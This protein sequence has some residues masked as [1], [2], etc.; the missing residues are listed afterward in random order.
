MTN[1][2]SKTATYPIAAGDTLEFLAEE[3]DETDPT[4][5]DDDIKTALIESIDD[6]DPDTREAAEKKVNDVV[7]TGAKQVSARDL[8]TYINK[9]GVQSFEI[10]DCDYVAAS[11]K[12]DTDDLITEETEVEIAELVKAEGDALTFAVDIENARVEVEAI[13]DMV[14]ASSDLSDWEKNKLEVEAEFDEGKV[15]ITPKGSPDKA[16]MR[17][18]IPKDPGAA[19]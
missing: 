11:V 19:E 2:T 9:N 17:V 10:A 7:G 6:D 5:T 3:A 15:T 12:L 18:V 16:F 14:E 8:A 1:V 4:V 13:K